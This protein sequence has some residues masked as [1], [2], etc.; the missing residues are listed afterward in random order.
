MLRTHL[1]YE[2]SGEPK[3]QQAIS[4][5]LIFE[6]DL[7]TKNGTGRKGN[8]CNKRETKAAGAAGT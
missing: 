6:C 1:D 7:K 3:L 4:Q 2:K 8:D 5:Y